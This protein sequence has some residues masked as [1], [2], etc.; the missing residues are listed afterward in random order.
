[1]PEAPALRVHTGIAQPWQCDVLGHLTTRF[2]VALFDEASYHFLFELFGWSGASDDAGR[3][4]FVDARHEIDYRQEV[5]AGTLLEIHARLE[6]VGNKSLVARYAMRRRG[7]ESETV[8]TLRATYVLFDL[9][10]RRALALDD[11]LRRRA[12]AHLPATE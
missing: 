9:E 3:R 4:A 11:E 1:M 2:Y 6:R 8:A 7:G 10:A 5:R 12:Q